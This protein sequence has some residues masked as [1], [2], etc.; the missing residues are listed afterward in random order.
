MF[1]RT[2]KEAMEKK[3]EDNNMKRLRKQMEQAQTDTA[4][5]D[6]LD[7][8]NAVECAVNVKKN[9]TGAAG[10]IN[11]SYPELRRANLSPKTDDRTLFRM[12]RKELKKQGYAVKFGVDSNGTP[13]LRIAW[14]REEGYDPEI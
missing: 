13:M 10:C 14:S 4:M 7:V 2:L 8:V 3:T 1:G 6:M 12:V 9:G 5:K 11:F